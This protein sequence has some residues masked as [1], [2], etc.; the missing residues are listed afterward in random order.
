MKSVKD[1]V[2]IECRREYWGDFCTNRAFPEAG[3]KEC[4]AYE[5]KINSYED[6]DP[7]CQI[8]GSLEQKEWY[9]K[10]EMFRTRP[11]RCEQ[12]KN[13]VLAVAAEKEK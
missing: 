2:I 1:V 9:A 12:C 3:R 13:A 11:L 6:T 8:W 5:D 7:Y 10:D 4:P